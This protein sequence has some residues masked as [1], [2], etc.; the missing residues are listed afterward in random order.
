MTPTRRILLF[1]DNTDLDRQILR[2]VDYS[3]F[4]DEWNRQGGGNSGNKLFTSAIEQYL[5]K[6]DIEYDYYKGNETV[7]VINDKYDLVVIPMANIFNANSSVVRQLNEYTTLIKGLRIPVYILGCGIQ[8]GSYDNI[9]ELADLIRKPVEEFLKAI[10]QSG[11]ELALRG[12]ATK[13]FLDKIMLNSAVVTGCPSFFQKGPNLQISN[14]KVK[15][16]IFRPVI[17][18]NLK[19]L[20]E[21][22]M[23]PIFAQ[24][25]NSIYM[26]QDEFAEWLYF[27]N[28]PLKKKNVWK[29]VRK[30][31]YYS[32]RL[33]TEDRVKLIYDIPCWIQYLE[34]E[35]F[36]FSCGSRIHGN[37]AA[38]LAGV[39]AM[40]IG[41]AHV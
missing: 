15:E 22:N 12:Y 36:H 3:A 29:L 40:E 8:C 2:P 7:D 33:L 30:K 21:V 6:E 14:E 34:E 27:K 26:D 24:Y 20:Q 41:R 13:E 10:Y 25:P 31:T 17:N 28:L 11:G 9:R 16:E 35:K 19:Y 23:L 37:I 18:G 5:N 1:Y 4:E 32:A 39:P 38:I